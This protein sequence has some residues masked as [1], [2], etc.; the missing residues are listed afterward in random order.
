MVSTKCDMMIMRNVSK[1]K[2]RKCRTGTKSGVD[3]STATPVSTN[4]G[5]VGR[6]TPRGWGSLLAL[7][8]WE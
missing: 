8:G 5:L 7:N 4:T 6:Q 1:R 2:Q 3:L